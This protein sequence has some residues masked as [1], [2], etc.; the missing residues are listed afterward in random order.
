MRIIHA[1]MIGDASAAAIL[2][3]QSISHQQLV[4]RSS[5]DYASY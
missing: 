1:F 3:I 4:C 5:S 2:S